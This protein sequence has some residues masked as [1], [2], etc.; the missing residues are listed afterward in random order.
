LIEPGVVKYVYDP[1]QAT[2]MIAD[3]GYQKGPD[4]VFL[5]SAGQRLTVETRTT[6]QRDQQVKATFAG[7]LLPDPPDHRFPAHH[8]REPR[9]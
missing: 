1:R 9:L 5:D 7:A 3:L 6:A 2:Q 8:E 4:G